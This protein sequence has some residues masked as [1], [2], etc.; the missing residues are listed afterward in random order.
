M[1]HTKNFFKDTLLTLNRQISGI[2]IGLLATVIIA[3]VLGPKGTGVYSLV[4]LL[5]T[6]LMTLLNFGVGS[7]SVYFVG[8]KR[9]ALGDILKTNTVS[10]IF[11][12]LV[13]I[14]IGL[15]LVLF[16]SDKF[17]KGV[18]HSYLYF[19]LVL[20]PIIMLNEFYICIFQGV[21]D[22]KSYNTLALVRQIAAL[23]FLVVFTF[24]INLGLSG[25]VYSFVVGVL[26]QFILTFYYFK[27][28]T[29]IGLTT[30]Q[31][32]KPYF[33]ESFKYGYKAH[34]S[35]ILSFVNYRADM[36]VISAFLNT[37]EVGIYSTAVNIAERLWIVSQSISSVLFPAVSS[38]D[39]EENKNNLTC[40]ISRNVLFF[41]ILGG[42]LFY[43]L[44]NIVIMFLYGHKYD[45]SVIVLKVLLP[46]II[47]FSVDRILSNDL[48]GR[49][50]PE[51]NMYVSIFTVISNLALNILLVPRFGLIGA[52]FS[53]SST[54]CLSTLIKV[55]LFK[56]NTK[57]SYYKIL[58]LQ[59]DD[60]SLYKQV[61]NNFIRRRMT[62]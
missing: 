18:P 55:I 51:L 59:R 42:I 7:S 28:R 27:K 24:A 29:Q 45:E 13:S 10:G 19:M 61:W 44:C 46:G 31:Y 41:S 40:M 23:L 20:M 3:R 38:L 39:D 49:G 54:Y 17:F 56:K 33:I 11:L 57:V 47:F 14:I 62:Q 16:F 37:T 8:K 58:I 34:F 48:A 25:T 5:P 21:Q 35:N 36:F 22:F 50:K 53:T 43:L 2:L 60:F 1:S 15:I 32:S 26:A 9:F 4:T 12:S 6:M 30:G 52:S